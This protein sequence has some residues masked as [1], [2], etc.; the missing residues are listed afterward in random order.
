VADFASKSA[1]C[2]SEWQDLNLRPP[3]PER[4]ALP[5]LEFMDSSPI[6]GALLQCRGGREPPI[7][8]ER[9]H[10]GPS[11]SDRGFIIDRSLPVGAFRE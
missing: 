8:P 10:F 6:W 5:D 2:W 9:D 4:G 3:R 1:K 7:E 11:R